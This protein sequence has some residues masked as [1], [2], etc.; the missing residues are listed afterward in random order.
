VDAPFAVK[1]T[2]VGERAVLRPFTDADIA[3]MG[4]ILADPEVNRL[5][6]SVGS[7][8]EAT[9]RPSELGERELE[10][11]RSRADQPD[12]LDLA[13]VDAATDACVGEV[14][15]NAYD[16][17]N[18]ACGFRILVGPRGRDR[19]LGTE[20]T[21]MVLRHAFATT[22]LHR[23]EL[24][25]YAFNPRAQRVYEKAGFVV[26]GRRRDALLF[27]GERVDAVLMSILRPEWAALA[28]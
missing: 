8:Q 26:E 16:G 23:V 7:T 14:V 17:D 10:W 22:D 2:L 24:E 12:R 9:T 4:P 6:G 27:D 28:G 21:R 13:L 19:G 20:A 1:P 11:Y 5:T 15:L 25:V 3:A 18:Q